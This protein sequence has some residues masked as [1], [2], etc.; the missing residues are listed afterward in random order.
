[1]SPPVPPSPRVPAASR[2]AELDTPRWRRQ[3]D[4]GGMDA[5]ESDRGW[6]RAVV[7][8]AAGFARALPP[9]GAHQGP[10]PHRRPGRPPATGDRHPGHWPSP[11]GSLAIATQVCPD[12]PAVPSSLS[13]CPCPLSPVPCARSV[14]SCKRPKARREGPP[15]QVA[16]ERGHSR[17]THRPQP[18]PRAHA[19]VP[20]PP[21]R[22][23]E[24][25]GDPEWPER[26]LQRTNPRAALPPGQ[27]LKGTTPLS[28][29]KAPPAPPQGGAAAGWSSLQAS[30]GS[31]PNRELLAEL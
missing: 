16:Q 20:G 21:S 11:P 23:Q 7:P 12:P 5:K 30:W 15:A 25:F 13:L 14:G 22:Q 1:L 6:D 26:K 2:R 18:A 17:T 9:R 8:E 4:R 24:D 3:Q 28:L 31:P 19:L 29:P 27:P 10:A